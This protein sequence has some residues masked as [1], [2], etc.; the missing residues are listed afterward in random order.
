M[1][2]KSLSRK[3]KIVIGVVV[4]LVAR[5][6]AGAAYAISIFGSFH[7]VE[8]VHTDSDLGIS[9]GNEPLDD[10]SKEIT[11]I[12]LF[13]V[14][15]RDKDSFKGN[16]D[17]VMVI[18]VDKLH[19]KIK[20]TSIMRDSIVEVDGYGD[21]KL[22][23]VYGLGGPKLAIRTINENFGLNIR[24]Y[25][26]VNFANMAEIV[27]AVG[28]VEIYVT[29]EERVNANASIGEQIKELGLSKD[30]PGINQAG[31]QT[32]NGIQAVGYARIR[33]VDN[34]NGSYGDYGRTDRQREVMEQMFN[35]ALKM[36]FWEYPEF[37]RKMIPL[38][39]TSLTYDKIF[40]MAKIMTR[41]VTFSQ[42]RVPLVEYTL[43]A[44]YYMNGQSCVYYN[45]SYASQVLRAYIY[46]DVEPEQ[47]VEENVP[48]TTGHRVQKSE[49]Y[50]SSN[51]GRSS[52]NDD[53][54]DDNT[55]TTSS[56]R[57]PSSSS[58]S[59][60]NGGTTSSSGNTSQSPPNHTSSIDPPNEPTEPEDPPE[61]STPPES[62]SNGN[63]DGSEATE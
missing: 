62:G 36:D 12:A 47:Y 53:D 37:I 59:S 24:D 38:V 30:T 22:T 48:P 60:N 61:S 33:Y 8:F 42:T 32:L 58:K 2:L 55:N 25:A 51:S 11:N 3:K 7:P 39:E 26:T 10:S 4:A 45:L 9:S 63:E 23:D 57:A 50:S 52:Y 43:D 1:I 28:G 54:D 15:S 5:L 6:G 13:G 19:N 21:R 20:L 35:K 14:D 27:D 46:D 31:L 18:S 56:Y 17:S 49:K 44:D 40:D 29:E 34:P 16:S 41:N